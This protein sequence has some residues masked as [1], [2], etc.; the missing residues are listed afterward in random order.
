MWPVDV[1]SE[2]LRGLLLGVVGP[3]GELDTARFAP[4]AGQHLRLDDDLAAELLGSGAGLGRRQGELTF[5]RWD[6]EAPEELLALEFVE[7]HRRRTLAAAGWLERRSTDDRRRQAS[8]SW[9]ADGSASLT[10]L[11]R[12]GRDRRRR[13]PKALRQLQ[14]LEGVSFAVR[15]GEV[16]FGPT[17][18]ASD[19]EATS[20]RQ[21]GRL[22]KVQSSSWAITHTT[23]PVVTA[24]P[25]RRTT[26]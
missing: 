23:C 10:R 9:R 1:E 6:A 20:G 25:A 26:R 3:V 12:R 18:H 24:W 4:P 19:A 22:L 8:I 2:D 13:D 21:A 17:S 14:A 7:I 16:A 11:G 5:R 15:A